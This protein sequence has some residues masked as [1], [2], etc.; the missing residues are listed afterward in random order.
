MLK[1]YGA[2]SASKNA[3]SK[4]NNGANH[5]DPTTPYLKYT[6]TLTHSNSK[7]TTLIL[8]HPPSY[9][10]IRKSW[11]LKNQNDILQKGDQINNNNVERKIDQQVIKWLVK[12]VASN[13]DLYC[14]DQR[15]NKLIQ[16]LTVQSLYLNSRTSKLTKSKNYSFWSIWQDQSTSWRIRLR[17]RS[18]FW[19]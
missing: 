2:A 17:E 1:D 14:G 15:S 7:L 3:M 16:N 12:Q 4:Q 9:K 18:H 8:Q 11:I 6:T 13:F 19:E 5:G 10:T